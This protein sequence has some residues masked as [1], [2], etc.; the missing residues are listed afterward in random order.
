M[1]LRHLSSPFIQ[2]PPEFLEEHLQEMKRLEWIFIGTRWLGVL[3]ILLMAWLH[4]PISAHAMIALAGVLGL[5]NVVATVLNIRIKHSNTQRR[6]GTAMLIV[7]TVIVWGVLLLFVDEFY[8]SAYAGFAFVI[9]EAAIRHGLLGSLV[10]GF[11]FVFGLLGAWIFRDWEFGVRFSVSGYAF[12]TIIMM[13]IALGIGMVV[14]E[15][16]RQRQ[17][18]EELIR[19]RALEAECQRIADDLHNRVIKTLHGLAMEAHVMGTRKPEDS[20]P[21]E[22]MAHYIKGVCQRT[23]QEIRDAVFELRADR[24]ERPRCSRISE[25]VDNWSRST[26]IPAEFNLTG[27]DV[28]LPLGT[29]NTLH[30]ILTEALANVKEHSLASQ[31]SVSIKTLPDRKST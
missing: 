10:I 16:Q 9:I 18:S 12:W 1:K 8:T 24:Q 2:A 21:V 20:P 22:Q 23:S 30:N 28:P 31:V 14:R 17:R 3:I 11:V 6:L 5:A 29:F 13:L 7:D 4:G 15:G 25:T 19:E 27:E 26:G